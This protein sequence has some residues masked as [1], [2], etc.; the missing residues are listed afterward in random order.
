MK[1]SNVTRFLKDDVRPY[2]TRTNKKPLLVQLREACA[3]YREYRYLPYHYFK[4]YLCARNVPENADLLSFVPPMIIQAIP[5]MASDSKKA[6][7]I[8]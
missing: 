7:K 1:A 3:L 5:T 8:P 6:R 4:S 2:L